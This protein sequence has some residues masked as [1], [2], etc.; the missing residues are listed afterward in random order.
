MAYLACIVVEIFLES[1]SGSQL[2][3][4]SDNLTRAIYASQWVDCNEK[5]KRMYRIFVERSMQPMVIYAGNLFELSLPTF[6]RVITYAYS[7]RNSIFISYFPMVA[8]LQSSIF[9]LFDS[10]QNGYK[11][12][13]NL[14]SKQFI[15]DM[16]RNSEAVP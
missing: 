1:L 16:K 2:T 11:F 9:L 15:C 10:H 5:Y 4:V 7:D 14:V 8:D 12:S 6:L 3:F 13:I